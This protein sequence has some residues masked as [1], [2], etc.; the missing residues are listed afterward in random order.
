MITKNH[1]SAYAEL[2]AKA[3]AVLREHGDPILYADINITNIDEYFACLKDLADI[4]NDNANIDPIFTILPATEATFNI[5]ADKRSI[6]IPENFAKYGVGVQG[7]EIAEILYFSID[8][9]F[10]AMDLADM[11]IIVQ[12]KHEQDADHVA[13]LSAT[14][15]K[16]LTLQPGKIV[17]GW[18][19]TSEVTER[20]GIIKFSIRFYRRNDAALE[21]SFST[22]TSAIK[23]QSGLDFEINS[24][25]VSDAINKNSLIYSNLRNSQKSTIDYVIATPAFTNYF[26]LDSDNNLNAVNANLQYDLPIAFIA[27]AEI[28]ENTPNDQQ[29]GG[30]GL[31]YSW[32]NSNNNS[33]QLPSNHYYK[34]VNSADAYNAKEIYYYINDNGEYEPYYSMGDNNLFDNE[35]VLYTRCSKFEPSTAGTYY[36]IATNTYAPGAYSLIKSAE[37]T[38]PGPIAPTFRYEEETRKLVI[39]EN[40][41]SISITVNADGELSGEWYKSDNVNFD[42][43]AICVQDDATITNGTSVFNASE[44]GYYFLKV[45]STKNNSTIDSI[46]SGVWVI[47]QADTPRIASCSVNGVT[48]NEP[49]FGAKTGDTLAVIVQAPER[50]I[51]SYQWRTSDNIAIEGAVNNSYIPQTIG[52]YYCTITNSYKGTSS[53]VDTD[54]F[55]VL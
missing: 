23:I 46:S 15:K 48:K 10:D 24:T 50:G 9:Y 37:W 53:E 47:K 27:K 14:Y 38:V 42:D 12:W 26:T 21:Y 28:P 54:L 43:S 8:R 49:P 34:Q 33:T 52:E 18:P 30:A 17:F 22:L 4:E 55:G 39:T 20:P 36:A 51:I 44:E 31:T 13:N 7:D 45:H 29:I 19:I 1:P 25:T 6:S 3:N 41:I 16:S 40:E 2:F 11:E 35:V 32:Y 5:D